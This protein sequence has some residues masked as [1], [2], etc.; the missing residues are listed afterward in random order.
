MTLFFGPQH[1][2]SGH[3]RFDVILDGDV[4]VDLI[5][6]VG[7]VH[8]GVE[9]IAETKKFVQAIPLVER[10]G[11]PDSANMNIGY[12]RAVEEILEIEC[13]ARARYIR[14][15]LCELSRIASHLYGI[16]IFGNMI[17]SST[18]YMWSF[19]DREIFI[20]LLQ[21][22]TGARLTYS[23]FLP[24]GVRGNPP[25]D[26]E[27]K[28]ERGLSYFE[29]RV[30]DYRSLVFDNPIVRGR[31]ED[32]GIISGEKAK[33]LGITGPN[34][35]ASGVGY[36]VRSFV[37]YGAYRELDF[38][39]ALRR[40]GDSFARLMI[41]F[42]E[43][44]ESIRLIRKSLEKMPKGK[45]MHEKTRSINNLITMNMPEGWAFSR[46]ECGRGELTYFIESDG[47][48]KPNRMRLITPSFRNLVA[49]REVVVG[50]RLAD[51]PA[52]YG[53]LDYFPPGADR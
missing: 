13:P 23:Y 24:G 27:E 41:R 51:L 3:L 43:I 18:V 21:E 2:G 28:V 46:V 50:H 36:D 45:I 4:I 7:W 52:I 19:S 25:Q 42:D 48:D 16:G 5:P 47:G 12:V 20:E 17:G 8:R 30:S 39:P 33:E 32:V 53:S 29:N 26:F 11:L 31:L 38:E 22:F 1:P 6:D 37:D 34:L 14:T 35:R 49:F 15:L 40:E 10:P 44:E 9:K